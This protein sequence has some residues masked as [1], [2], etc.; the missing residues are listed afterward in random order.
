VS[1]YAPGGPTADVDGDGHLDV[2]LDGFAFD[3]APA[4]L[5]NTTAG[6]HWLDVTTGASGNTAG[7]GARVAVYR[8]GGL[9]RTGDLLGTATIETGN[10]FSS[11]APAVAHFGLGEV[12]RVDIEV[13]LPAGGAVLTRTGV[14]ADQS[15]RVS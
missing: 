2:L 9:G 3:V 14:A 13:I 8:A 6:G 7:I 5:R 11:A 4:L 12:T 10:G 1:H 15:L